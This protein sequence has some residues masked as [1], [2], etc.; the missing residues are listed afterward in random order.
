MTASILCYSTEKLSSETEV[1][2]LGIEITTCIRDNLIDEIFRD[3]A[4]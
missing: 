2:I 4:S 3:C 1:L